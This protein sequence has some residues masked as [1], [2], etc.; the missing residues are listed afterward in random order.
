M[1]KPREESG[2]SSNFPK[3]K[4]G[5]RTHDQVCGVERPGV[6]TAALGLQANDFSPQFFIAKKMR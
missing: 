2:K 1:R 3:L 6:Y 4:E 5:M